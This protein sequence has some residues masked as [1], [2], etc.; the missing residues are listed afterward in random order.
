[1][2]KT[3]TLVG[4]CDGCNGI[5]CAYLF[6]EVVVSF[7]A[8]AHLGS[9]VGCYVRGGIRDKYG[10]NG[11]GCFDCCLHYFCTPCVMCQ[12]YEELR[13]KLAPQTAYP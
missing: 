1:M 9:I 2:T 10:V 5:C 8:I 11:N 12:E 4:P 3:G 13:M 7:S 6:L